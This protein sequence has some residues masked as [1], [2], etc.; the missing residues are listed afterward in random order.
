MKRDLILLMFVILLATFG[1]VN[2]QSSDTAPLLML[3]NNDLWSWT[4]ESGTPQ[5]LTSAGYIWE[6]SL[7]PDGGRLAYM[8]YPDLTIDAIERTD[9]IGGGALPS[10]IWVLDI[11]GGETT[12]VA[13]QPPDAAF[14]T[15]S[16]PDKA[17]ARSKPAWSQDGTMLA[18]TELT[19]PDYTDQLV[20]YDLASEAVVNTVTGLPT[21]AGVPVPMEMSWG[22]AG[23]LLRSVTMD[24]DGNFADS[25]LIYDTGSNQLSSV[26]VGSP[27]RFMIDYLWIEQDG[28]EYIGVQFNDRRWELLAPLTGDMQPMNGLP[29]MYSLLAPNTSLSLVWS[30]DGTLRAFNSDGTAA[31]QLNAGHFV[32]ER[33]ALSPSGRAIAFS[34]FLPESGLYENVVR[35]WRDEQGTNIPDVAENQIVNQIVWGPIAWRVQQET[36]VTASA[37]SAITTCPG[38][39]PSRLIAGGQGRVLGSEPNNVRAEP[40]VNSAR[41]GEIPGEG[42]FVVLAGPVCAD[43]YAW[44]QVD[45]NGLVGWTA[46]GEGSVYWLEPVS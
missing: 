1:N 6:M 19:F 34:D 22:S 37:A 38:L 44:W 2:A 28:Q 10:D 17:V 30:P 20:I 41:L 12:R 33:V 24:A 42:V 36:S 7:S 21:Q 25:F 27:E 11:A 45:Y 23:I 43:G 39:L 14:F 26:P 40:T 29:A 31:L 35:V 46:E 9:G 4:I 15:E 5:R 18:W 32:I 8:S 16:V 3:I 13:Q